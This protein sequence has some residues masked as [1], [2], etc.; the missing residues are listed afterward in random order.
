MIA[1]PLLDA[2]RPAG[3]PLPVIACDA[4]A[5]QL[6]T[7]FDEWR[8]EP[9]R[10][11]WRDGDAVSGRHFNVHIAPLRQSRRRAAALPADA[12]RSH[13]RD[14]ER[15]LAPRRTPSRQ[16]H[17]PAQSQRVR[18]SGRRRRRGGRR[19]SARGA[20]R[21]SV[22][23]QPDQRELGRGRRRRGD[24]H[25]RAPADLDAAGGRPARAR[26]RG[27]VRHPAAPRQRQRRCGGGGPAHPVGAV[28]AVPLGAVRGRSRMRDRLCA[29]RRRIGQRRG[30]GA[31]RAVRAQAR[32]DDGARRGPSCGRGGVRALQARSRDR[33]ASRDRHGR[34]AARLSADRRSGR[35]QDQRLRGAGALGASG[36]RQHRSGR[37]HTCCRGGGA[38]RA[39]RPL[40]A[41]YRAGDAWRGGTSSPVARCR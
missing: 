7:F 41:R 32:Q 31:Q 30:T 16:P 8:T 40:G 2:S 3:Q 6:R 12:G 23:V 27:R 21:R 38:D 5:A 14:L 33:I 26:R 13:R 4:V 15:A 37:V 25:G 34:P 28:L 19:R 22:A 35:Q 17:R 9:T 24:H 29:D 36:A 20:A 11:E 18:R 1:S 10:F 39:A